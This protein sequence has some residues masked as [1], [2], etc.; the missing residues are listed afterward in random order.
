MPRRSNPNPLA[1]AIGLRIKQL[2]KEQ[3]ITAEKLAY[4]SE[5][6]SK[7]FVSDI[8]H[9]LA[10][11]SLTTL[12]RIAQRLEV[13]VFDLLIVPGRSSREQLI[14][15]TRSMGPGTLARLLRDLKD[16][17]PTVA[18]N[19]VQHLHPIDAFTSLE[20]AAGWSRP[21]TALGEPTGEKV[22]LSGDFDKQRD[23]AVRAFGNSMAG[24]RST[25]RDGDWLVLRRSER[26]PGASVGQVVLV[27][28]ED[29]Y[30]DKSLH[31]KR[32]VESGQRLWFRSDDSSVKPIVVNETDRVLARLVR[33]V[34]PE[35]LAPP[36][37]TRWVGQGVA[38]AFGVS[39]EPLSGWSRVDGHLFFVVPRSSIKPKG[40]VAVPGCQPR[41]AET[42][43]VILSEDES[44]EY[45][46]VARYDES[47]E[48]WQLSSTDK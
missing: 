41:P 7:G 6:G 25:I 31:L 35:S 46:G 14:E 2:R 32:V 28:R 9:G 24:F 43:F 33:V 13:S 20:V 37:H 1:L 15:F 34:S 23:F 8:E 39:S 40:S 30:G 27:M 38:P 18:S 22:G 11:P 21:A 5:V 47:R 19:K 42:A 16:L 48:R 3:D 4:E 26:S 44:L 17:P 10:L 12:E 29:P 36:V 45:M